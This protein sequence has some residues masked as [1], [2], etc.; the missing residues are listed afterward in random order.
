MSMLEKNN[1]HLFLHRR[2]NCTETTSSKRLSKEIYWIITAGHKPSSWVYATCGSRA[3]AAFTG[4]SDPYSKTARRCTVHYTIVIR[5]PSVIDSINDAACLLPFQFADFLTFSNLGI[6][7]TLCP[8]VTMTVTIAE[9]NKTTGDL[10]AFMWCAILQK[11]LGRQYN[12]WALLSVILR[13]ELAVSYN[14]PSI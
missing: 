3:P 1:Y 12:Y 11:G 5:E 14:T 6:L 13:I 7:S 4:S 8:V 2:K 10:R 9:N